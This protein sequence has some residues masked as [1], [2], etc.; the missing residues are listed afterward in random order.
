MLASLQKL[1]F[2]PSS[3]RCVEVAAIFSSC[4]NWFPKAVPAPGVPQC[5]DAAVAGGGHDK[6]HQGQPP[7]PP[8]ALVAFVAYPAAP[9]DPMKRELSSSP[10]FLSI[11]LLN[12]RET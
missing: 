1:E 11:W 10:F 5:P 4:I 12:K 2:S 3:D 7:S 9:G 6:K 8:L